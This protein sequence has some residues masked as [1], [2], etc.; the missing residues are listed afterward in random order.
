MQTTLKARTL[1]LVQARL[2]THSMRRLATELE[3][4][5]FWLRRFA[6]GER[7][8]YDADTVQR[9]YEKLAGKQIEL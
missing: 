8:N 5:Y 4:D 9:V 3:I 2:E 1:E 7:S 6:Y